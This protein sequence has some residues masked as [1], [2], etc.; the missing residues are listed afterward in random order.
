MAETE[1]HKEVK[2]KNNYQISQQKM[3]TSSIG[4]HR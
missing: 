2:Y 3:R 1:N 4:I